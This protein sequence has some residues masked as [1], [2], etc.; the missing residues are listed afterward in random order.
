MSSVE[1]RLGYKI[2][3][4]HDVHQLPTVPRAERLAQHLTV[5]GVERVSTAG[6]VQMLDLRCASASVPA[7]LHTCQGSRVRP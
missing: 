2:P 6:K 3:S 4:T 5:G 7:E 1:K